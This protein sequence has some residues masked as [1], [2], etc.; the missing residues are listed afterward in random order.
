[1][2]RTLLIAL[3]GI[4]AYITNANYTECGYEDEDGTIWDLTGLSDLTSDNFY[5]LPDGA[6]P[7][8]TA[9]FFINFCANISAIPPVGNCAQSASQVCINGT[10]DGS[11]CN[12]FATRPQNTLTY[13]YVA[14]PDGSCYATAGNHI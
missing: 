10:S 14:F 11:T 9:T 5:T 3:S 7:D 2:N 1:M 13:G 12:E 4:I 8:T 6:T